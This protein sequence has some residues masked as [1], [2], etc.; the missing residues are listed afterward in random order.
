M[1]SLASPGG[2]PGLRVHLLREGLHLLST[3]ADTHHALHGVHV[4]DMPVLRVL[5]LLLASSSWSSLLCRSWGC[6]WCRCSR[7]LGW[8][9]VHAGPSHPP[10]LLLRL[11]PGPAGGRWGSVE[12][13]ATLRLPLP[14]LLL[15]TPASW[16]LSHSC[17]ATDAHCPESY[18]WCSVLISNRTDSGVLQVVQPHV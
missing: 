11:P 4:A 12:N 14:V 1:P 16:L 10:R 3:L 17:L 2:I 15:P 13:L 8:S 7:Y 5:G 18:S 9:V 6:A